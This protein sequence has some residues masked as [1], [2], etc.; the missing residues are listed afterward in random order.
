MVFTIDGQLQRQPSISCALVD[1]YFKIQQLV[2][3]FR[4][5]AENCVVNG[6]PASLP[7]IIKHVL[8]ASLY[9][10][11]ILLADIFRQFVQ[12]LDNCL[13]FALLDPFQYFFE[14]LIKVLPDIK[15]LFLLFFFIL[16]LFVL[17]LDFIELLFLIAQNV[18]QVLIV[19]IFAF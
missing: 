8:F 12:D 7:Q 9:F 10:L 4:F 19:R 15:R 16:L 17:L 3:D 5:V 13:P 18:H 2:Q 1:V 6:S 14:L 11:Y